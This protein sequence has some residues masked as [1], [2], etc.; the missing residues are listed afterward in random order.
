WTL[1]GWRRA[2]PIKRSLATRVVVPL[3]RGCTCVMQHLPVTADP[4]IT[5]HSIGRKSR[6]SSFIPPKGLHSQ[7]AELCSS[8]TCPRHHRCSAEKIRSHS[9]GIESAIGNARRI[10]ELHGFACQAAGQYDLLAA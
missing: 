10:Q 2:H 9:A 6:Q 4:T 8:G 7:T 1:C 3:K 5:A